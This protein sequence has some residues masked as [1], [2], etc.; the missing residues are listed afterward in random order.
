MLQQLPC[1]QGP[2]LS[3]DEDEESEESSEEE[4]SLESDEDASGSE[5]DVFDDSICPNSKLGRATCSL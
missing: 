4:S 2:L 5:D 3:L 1:W